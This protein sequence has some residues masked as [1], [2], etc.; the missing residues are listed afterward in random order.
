MRSSIDFRLV[1]FPEM[2]SGFVGP[3]T[4]HLAWPDTTDALGNS[5]KGQKR[6]YRVARGP[7][8]A[9][10]TTPALDVTFLLDFAVTL[11]LGWVTFPLLRTVT[12]LLCTSY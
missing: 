2:V 12:L 5:E 1:N 3:P 7:K 9:G 8:V 6:K 4:R 10:L 11:L